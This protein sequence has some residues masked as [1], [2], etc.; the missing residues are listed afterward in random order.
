MSQVTLLVRAGQMVPAHDKPVVASSAVVV[1]G[2]TISCS[3]FEPG[4]GN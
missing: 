4:K 3:S 2:E 1:S